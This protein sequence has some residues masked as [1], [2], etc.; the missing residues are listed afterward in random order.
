MIAADGE[1]VPLARRVGLDGPVEAW[2]GELERVMRITLARGLSLAL[3]AS[4]TAG[5]DR[6]TWV[7]DTPGQLLLTAASVLFTGERECNICY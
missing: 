7:K 4:K 3:P 2:L 5:A 1:S 6:L